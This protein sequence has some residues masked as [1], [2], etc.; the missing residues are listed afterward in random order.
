M[1]RDYPRMAGHAQRSGFA[2]GPCLFKDT[3]QLAAANNNNFLLGHAAMLINE[4]LPNFVVRHIKLRV[5]RCP[6]CASA[7]SAW[8]SRPTATTR[9][10]RSRTSS[11]RSSSTRRPRCSAPTSYIKDPTFLPLD[12]VVARSDLLILGAPHREYRGSRLPEGKPVVDIWN[13]YGKG[14]SRRED[15]RHRLGRVHRR[16][17]RRGAARGRATRSSG[18]TTTPSTGP[19]SA[20]VRRPPALPRRH[21][22]RQGRRAACD[23][24]LDGCD[25][26]VAGAAIIGG[27]SLF[28]ELAY[29]LIAENERIT[30]AA[31]DAAIGAHRGGKLQKITVV[32]SSMVYESADV[33][34][35]PEGEQRRARRRGRPTASRSWRPSI[36]PKG[37][38]EQYGLPYTIVRPFNCVGIGERSGATRTRRSC[39][40][41]SSWR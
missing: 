38:R 27:I 25:H 37:R 6:R 21:G 41:T 5:R 20:V 32:S 30:A 22:R 39:R 4:G 23:E 14:A 19:S 1:T 13:I 18:S 12:E 16:L 31:F 29:D 28:H 24:L 33:Y 3:M 15:S 8:R 9:A 35:T 40:A 7:C 11:A 2:A 34:P 26:F 36:S 10:S 17:P